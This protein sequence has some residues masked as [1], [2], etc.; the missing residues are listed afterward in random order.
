M[1]LFKFA[2]CGSYGS[3]INQL[4]T[5]APEKWSFGDLNDNSIL[6]N[7]IKYTF[8]RLCDENKIIETDTHALFNTGLFDVY[9]RPIFAYFS[10][11]KNPNK[12]KWFLDSFM[13]EYQLT[14]LGIVEKPERANYFE[15]PADLVFD[16]R[17]EIVAQY[18]H[19]FGDNDNMQRFPIS[20]RHSSMKTA[21]FD[22][23]LQITKKMLE[24]NYKIAVPQF[25]NGK[26]QLLLPICLQNDNQPDLALVCVKTE[27]GTK[28]LGTTCLTL[29][30]AYNNARLIAK[31]ESNWLHA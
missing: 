18:E 21:L 2:Y 3:V 8:A 22:S 16:T 1:E 7:Y 4:A 24:A 15:N 25:Y 12:Q 27:N 17:L 31:P 20:I 23:A 11:N 30:M 9:Y 13:T 28:Y 5:L 14:S 29:E 19:I 6:K 26:V 10:L